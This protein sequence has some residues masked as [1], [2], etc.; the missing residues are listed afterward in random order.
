MQSKIW[1]CAGPLSRMHGSQSPLTPF[2]VTIRESRGTGLL[3]ES[4][5]AGTKPA[6]WIGKSASQ[7]PEGYVHVC[8]HTC[9]T[10]DDNNNN[11]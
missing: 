3:L 10:H 11:N 8:L 2:S 5:V 6:K 7:A 9:I 4:T 1:L